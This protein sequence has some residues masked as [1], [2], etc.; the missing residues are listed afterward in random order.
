MRPHY[1][2]PLSTITPVYAQEGWSGRRTLCLARQR[3]RL[4]V[5]AEQPGQGGGGVAWRG[6]YYPI[7]TS[8]TRRTLAG[9]RP[10]LPLE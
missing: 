8:A 7:A 5:L 6:Y 1:T 10:A 3:H 9:R 2:P 4:L